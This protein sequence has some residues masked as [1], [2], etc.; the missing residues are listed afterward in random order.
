VKTK[1]GQTLLA[2]VLG[3][4]IIWAVPSAYARGF[5]GGFG[6]GRGFGGGFGGGRSFGGDRSF[7]GG[8]RSFG[9]GDRSF[10]GG[11]RSFGGG[12]RSFGGGDHSWGG[13]DHSW[14]G[15]DHS[16]GGGDHSW[17]GGDHSWAGGTHSWSGASGNHFA[18]DGGLSG[19]AGTQSR[20]PT[21]INQTN[22]SA[23]GKSMRNSFDNDNVY[24]GGNTYNYNH[25]GNTNVGGYHANGYGGY[26]GYGYGGYGYHGYGYGGY[27]GWGYPGSWYVPGWSAATAWTCAGMATLGGFLGL[28]AMG[29]GGGSSNNSSSNV[30]YQNDNV[31]INGQPAGSAEQYYQQAQQLAGAG[32]AAAQTTA[33][34]VAGAVVATDASQQWQPLGVFA[35]AEPGQSQSNMLLQ[36][37]VNKDGIVRGNYFNQLTNESSEVYGSVNK[38]SERISWTIGTNKNTVFDAGLTDLTKDDS[39]VLVHY[40]PDNTQRMALIRM[41]QPPAQASQ[42]QSPT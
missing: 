34:P 25:I 17:A 7:G 29:G 41:Q 11:D 6:G 15:G 33:A 31:Y 2:L 42:Q 28:A 36:L 40:G 38:Q 13:G 3:A 23:Q 4:N 18:T 8:D 1:A 16:W 21:Q 35:L 20:N 14:G 5:G 27:H 26:H 39:S 37:A 30:T 22:L 12:D 19:I 24:K 10:G 32:I 9:G